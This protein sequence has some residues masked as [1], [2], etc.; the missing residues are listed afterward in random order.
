MRVL[1]NLIDSLK[2]SIGFLN[3]FMGFLRFNVSLRP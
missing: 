2:D 1:K 3:D